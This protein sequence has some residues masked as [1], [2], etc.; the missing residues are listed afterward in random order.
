MSHEIR[1]PLNGMLG[2]ID[3]TLLTTLTKEQRN[4]LYIA[5]DCAATLL[6]L[7]NDILDFSKIEARKLSLE[8]IGFD[9]VK[10]MEQ[11][12][13]PHIIKAEG[14]GLRFTYCFDSKIP[15]AVKGDPNRLRQILTTFL[16]MQLN[17]RMREK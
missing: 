6:N 13:K 15:P 4:N 3:L 17:L 11:T 10:N 14:K 8:S 5:K 9:F 1:T 16:E 2:M 7:I 12:I